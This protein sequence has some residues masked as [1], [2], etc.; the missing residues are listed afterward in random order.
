MLISIAAMTL[1]TATRRN[2]PH[3]ETTL[4]T[5]PSSTQ[6]LYFRALLRRQTKEAL[7]RISRESELRYQLASLRRDQRR[8]YGGS[9]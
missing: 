1:T 7:L 8:Q 2:P 9:P 6:V 3:T 4:I 5:L